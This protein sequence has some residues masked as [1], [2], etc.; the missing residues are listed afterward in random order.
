MAEARARGVVLGGLR[1]KT[2][3]LNKT[4][5]AN[6][7]GRAETIR[8]IITPIIKSG[9]TSREIAGGLNVVGLRTE[10]G[11]LYQAT[12][13]SHVKKRLGLSAGGT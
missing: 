11:A 4:R 1:D 7:V 2:N 12:T 13:V 10:R 8:S 9:S 3:K 6:A 5:Q